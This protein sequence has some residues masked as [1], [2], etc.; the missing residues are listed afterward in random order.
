MRFHSPRYPI[1]KADA[2]RQKEIAALRREKEDVERTLRRTN[3]EL[4]TL[5]KRL[6]KRSDEVASLKHRVGGSAAAVAAS[7]SS[8]SVVSLPSLLKKSKDVSAASSSAS[9]NNNNNHNQI[10]ASLHAVAAVPQ[11]PPTSSSSHQHTPRRSSNLHRMPRDNTAILTTHHDH[12]STSGSGSVGAMGVIPAA[13]VAD[14]KSLVADVSGHPDLVS[15]LSS[16]LV[17]N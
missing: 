2:R 13:A 9:I 6:D 15:T 1:L 16:L 11:Q 12:N 7:S 8:S 3:E 17:K 14:L 5:R 4:E 10:S